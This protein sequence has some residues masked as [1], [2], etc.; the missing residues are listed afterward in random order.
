MI[1][2]RIK[3]MHCDLE[4]GVDPT[5]TVPLVCTCGKVS[6]NNGI[7]TEGVQGTD[8]VDVSPQLLNE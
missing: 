4:M 3:C 2:K 8:W 6:L 7:I 1:D 5:S